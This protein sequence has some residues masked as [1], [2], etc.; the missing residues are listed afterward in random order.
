M[1]D[2]S[3]LCDSPEYI[4]AEWMQEALVAGAK[5]TSPRLEAIE[6]ENLGATT[7]AFGILLRCHLIAR[8][9]SSPLAETVIVKLSG[10]DR[11]T[12]R[13]AKWLSLHRREHDYYRRLAQHTPIRSP[14]LHYGEFNA[15]DHRFVLVLEDLHPMVT[16]PQAVGVDGARAHLAIREVARMHGRYW[17]AVDRPPVS[18]LY[19]NFNPGCTRILQTAYLVCLPTALE[20][21]GDYFSPKM[22]IFAEELGPRLVSHFANVALGPRTLSHGD[23]RAEN[24]FFGGG[25]EDDFAVID[26]QGCGSGCGLADVAYFLATSVPVDARRQ[27]E[28]ETLEEY[29]DIICRMGARNFTFE[30]CWRSYRQNI[31]GAFMACILGCGGFDLTDRR[32]RDLVTAL[33]RRTLAAVE[34]LD[35]EEF[36]PARERILTPGHAFSTLSRWGYGVYRLTRR[37]GRKKSQ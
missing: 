23:Y 18:G 16:I 36:L 7:N 6:V 1:T 4:T 37:M 30:D 24:M 19:D 33:L 15:R 35:A 29:H 12:L 11:K 10:T 28:R 26:W 13:F 21:F 5:A 25:T 20:R 9:D 3:L 8:D 2:R 14:S 32:R 31:L 17:G 34:D 22:R 27:M